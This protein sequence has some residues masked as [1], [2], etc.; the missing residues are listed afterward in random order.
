MKNAFAI[1]TYPTNNLSSWRCCWIWPEFIDDTDRL[2]PEI[3]QKWKWFFF[4]SEARPTQVASGI[5]HSVDLATWLQRVVCFSSCRRDPQALCRAVLPTVYRQE[6]PHFMLY[7]CM[8]SS[9]CASPAPAG[10]GVLSLFI[11]RLIGLLSV[12]C[13]QTLDC[14][15]RVVISLL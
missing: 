3:N 10:S 2:N 15:F 14:W 9:S 5:G 6:H 13:I 4:C 12:S 7:S 8:P 11:Y 1:R